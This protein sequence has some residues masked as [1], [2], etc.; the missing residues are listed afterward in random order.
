MFRSAAFRIIPARAGF[1]RSR[2]PTCRRRGDHPR[3][4]GVYRRMTEPSPSLT[5]SSPLARGL[6]R[7]ACKPQAG[8]RIIPARAGFTAPRLQ[9]SA[10]LADHPRSRGVYLDGSVDSGNRLGS[11]PLARGL[12]GGSLVVQVAGGIIPARAGFTLHVPFR[13]TSCRDHPRSRGVYGI[14]IYALVTQTG[15]SP[16]ARGLLGIRRRA[17]Q[18]PRIIPARAGFTK[19]SIPSQ[20]AATD[21]P[22]SRGVYAVGLTLAMTA[23]GSSPL[24]RGLR[25]RKRKKK[26]YVR[27]IPARAGF[28]LPAVVPLADQGDH[29]RSRGVYAM[30]HTPA[31]ECL[32]SSPLARGLHAHATRARRVRRIIPARAG[33]THFLLV[34]ITGLVDHPRSRGVYEVGVEAAGP[35]AGSSPLA[36][37]LRDRRT[38]QVPSHRIIPARAGFTKRFRP[39]T[40][41][42]RDHPRS[43]GVYTAPVLQVSRADG[44][45]PLARGLRCPFRGGGLEAGIIPA[46]AGFTAP[47]AKTA[48]PTTDHPRSRGVYRSSTP[49]ASRNQGSS[50]LARGLPICIFR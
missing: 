3:S 9:P 21:H 27:I 48:T 50:P 14:T 47:T 20:C 31:D 1:T 34:F 29:P 6:L 35:A 22:R 43:R 5:G 32:G 19:T 45:S 46:R 10:W 26:Y 7:P 40:P 13:E 18:I 23:C 36:R 30:R 28:T 44:S 16:L 24:A 11:S 8:R 49:P 41:A 38:S 12:P 33:F 4:R 25:K 39:Q 2:S 37:G 42:P 17:P 15:S